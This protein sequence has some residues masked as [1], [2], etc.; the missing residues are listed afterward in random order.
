LP[1]EAFA[2]VDGEYPPP[3][4]LIPEEQW[5]GTMGG[6]TDV[7]LRT[8]CHQGT[9]LAQL[10]DLW[11]LWIETM[12]LEPDQ[13]PFM[14][15]AALD[16]ADDFQAATFSAAHGYYRQGMASLRSA[17]DTLTISAGFAVR[18][19]EDGLQKW[20]GGRTEPKFGNAREFLAAASNVRALEQALA[21]KDH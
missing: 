8:S 1:E 20:L 4:D 13:A 14:F 11:I 19:D 6:P 15:N 9:P 21:T 5:H 18:Q 12:A 3:S 2:L 10:Y 16:A 17:L 7:L